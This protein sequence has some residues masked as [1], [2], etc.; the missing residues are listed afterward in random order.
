[1][2]MLRGQATTLN[3]QIDESTV[4]KSIYLVRVGPVWELLV[5]VLQEDSTHQCRAPVGFHSH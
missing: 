1:V 3:E 5:L 4:V 2:A